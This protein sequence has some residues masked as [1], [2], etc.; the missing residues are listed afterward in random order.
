MNY[1]H[2]YKVNFTKFICFLENLDEC[3]LIYLAIVYDK[4]FKCEKY[5]I[6]ILAK[7]RFIVEICT[8]KSLATVA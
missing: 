1:C 8:Q 2:V 5:L 6:K 7:F 3:I 4:K